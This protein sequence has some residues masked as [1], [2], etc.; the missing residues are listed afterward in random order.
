MKTN[1]TDI[2]ALLERFYSGETTLTEEQK[3]IQ[4]FS[5]ETDFPA[6]LADEAVFFKAMQVPNEDTFPSDLPEKIQAHITSR[7]A[8]YARLPKINT[9]RITLPYKRIAAAVAGVIILIS[10]SIGGVIYQKEQTIRNFTTCETQE[11]A[12]KY[13][14]Y[15]LEKLD[16]YDALCAEQIEST[17]RMLD[18]HKQRLEKSK[19]IIN[20]VQL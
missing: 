5:M 13:L 15:A 20:K 2:R 19:E 16:R 9:K 7:D 4:F 1:Y 8:L 10:A 3:L 18:N 14:A 11:E 12:D 6:D 17:A